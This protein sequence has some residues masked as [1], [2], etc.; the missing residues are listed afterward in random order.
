MAQEVIGLRTIIEEAGRLSRDIYLLNLDAI[1][2]ISAI[3]TIIRIIA[4]QK[5]ALNIP[6]TNSHD[7]S[8]V[9]SAKAES[10]K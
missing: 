10:N 3:T 7:V 2:T 5:P 4:D 9:D 1:H 6:C 8:K